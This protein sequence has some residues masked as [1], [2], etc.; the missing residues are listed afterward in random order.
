[1]TTGKAL[2]GKPYA[3]NPHVRFDEG[4]VAP[5][6]TPRR[7]SLLYNTKTV[8]A[9]LAAVVCAATGTL[10]ADVPQV[11][12]T[13]FFFKGAEQST[14]RLSQITSGW[15]FKNAAS[16][17]TYD[18][19]VCPG[20]ANNVYLRGGT[21]TIE[22]GDDLAYRDFLVG[23]G[24][25]LYTTNNI[26]G[27]SLLVTN[28]FRVGHWSGGHGCVNMSGGDVTTQ[29]LQLGVDSDTKYNRPCDDAKFNLSG[30]TL[31]LTGTKVGVLTLALED[32]SSVAFMQTGGTI[33]CTGNESWAHVGSGTGTT[34]TYTMTG[35][36]FEMNMA[37]NG[38]MVIGGYGTGTFDISGDAS[39]SSTCMIVGERGTGVGTV[40]LS[41]DATL[42]L[43]GSSVGILIMGKASGAVATF[44]QS[45][46]TLKATGNASYVHVGSASGSTAVYNMTGGTLDI[47]M[48]SNGGFVVGSSGNGTLNVSNDAS[49]AAM[50]LFIAEKAGSVGVVNLG[51]GG[52]I[53]VHCNN[54]SHSLEAGSGSGTF[55]FDGGTLKVGDGNSFIKNNLATTVSAKGG[56]IDTQG[57]TFTVN[58]EI[59]GEGT[60]TLAGGGTVVFTVAPTCDIS[61]TD[62]TTVTMPSKPT[63]ALTVESGVVSLSTETTPDAITLGKAGFVEYDLSSIAEAAFSTNLAT[64]V[65]ITTTDG[66][67]VPEH[68]ITKNYGTSN[69]IVGYCWNVSYSGTTLS[70]VS[71]DGTS[72]KAGSFTIFSGGYWNNGYYSTDQ[73][74]SW[75][76]G[77]PTDRTATEKVIVP[78]SVPA[79][80]LYSNID[81]ADIVMFR[82][83]R[84]EGRKMSSRIFCK[85]ISGEGT[86]T[87]FGQTD[88]TNKAYLG[89]PWTTEA[90]HCDVNVPI[91]LSGN[92]RHISRTES[93][94][95]RFNKPV[96]VAEGASVIPNGG[97]SS[98]F[99]ETDPVFNDDVTIDGSYK[100]FTTLTIAAGKTLSGKGSV[101][102]NLATG[103][104]AKLAVEIGEGGAVSP[105][106][107]SGTANL[108][109]ASLELS[110]TENIADAEKGTRIVLFR[111]GAIEG[112]QRQIVEIDGEKWRIVTRPVTDETTSTTYQALV[113]IKGVDGFM[114]IIQ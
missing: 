13:D 62:G 52:T 101:N 89:T 11:Q 93:S 100:P 28:E 103:S 84:V 58:C 106:T 29:L 61:I 54:Y 60:L 42:N 1:M 21:F 37:K 49:F 41:G 102:G 112:W 71:F 51:E 3:G 56:T 33:T 39:F 22:D 43:S 23:Q 86:L 36:T 81:C 66:S 92:V 35:G 64:N 114:V 16:G 46:G 57:Y 34:A 25:S 50:A 69:P 18:D 96:T 26:T 59:T 70:A 105:L 110:G 8:C 75:V 111:A 17:S 109:G 74:R 19:G 65:A 5:A 85:S 48:A 95:L 98:S 4:E 38:A 94:L 88:R 73:P 31:T 107:V 7:G 79:V 108:T 76:N 45:G 20:I 78:P 68:V 30:G 10:Y 47:C 77:M 27:G 14:Y 80:H 87:F 67:P 32:N 82:D 44:N 9:A 113:A 15:Q 91:I 55:N 40:N 12:G 2:N 24:W 90:Y 53:T 72:Q 6:A 104:G 83:L 97:A 63:G 99:P